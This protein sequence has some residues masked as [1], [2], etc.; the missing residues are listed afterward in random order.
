MRKLLLFITALAVIFA[1][2]VLVAC[3]GNNA[4]TDRN[5]FP[6][7]EEAAIPY[8]SDFTCNYYSAGGGDGGLIY[9]SDRSLQY[10]SEEEILIKIGFTLST[11][12]F[13]VGKTSLTIKPILSEGFFGSLIRANT[14]S[15]DDSDLTAVY[16]ADD[17]T[18]KT[19]TIEIKT[20]FNYYNGTIKIGYRYDSDE[21]KTTGSY[22][23]LCERTLKFTYDE[24]T[25]GYIA[26]N[27]AKDGKNWLTVPSSIEMPSEF[28]GKPI[29]G[30]AENMFSGCSS[31]KNLTLPNELVTIGSGAFRGCSSM[32]T[33]SIPDSVTHIG[34][35]AFDMCDSLEFYGGSQGCYYL[36]NETNEILAL[37]KLNK[38]KNTTKSITIHD[39]T[40]II[41]DGLFKDYDKLTEIR[42]G[43]GVT[44]IC[45]ELFSGCVY[46]TY[47]TIGSGVTSIGS[48][49]FY[50]CIRMTDVNIPDGVTAI[51]DY[52]FFDCSSVKNLTLPS[53][54]TTIGANAFYRC[55]HGLTNV[56]L[57][58]GLTT[59]ESETFYACTDLENITIP[60]GVTSIGFG[61]FGECLWLTSVMIPDSVTSIGK[62]AFNGCRSLT[63]ITIPDTVTSIGSGAFNGCRSLTSVTLPNGIKRIE[64]YTFI[65]CRSLTSVTLPN[66]IKKIERSAFY[67]S[68]LTSLILPDGLTDID[69]YAFQGC[70]GLT[71]LTVPN[72]VTSI[73]GVAFLD[74]DSLA[75]IRFGGTTE[76]WIE[77]TGTAPADG[78]TTV[79]CKNGEL[80]FDC[81]VTIK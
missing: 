66:G 51:G 20:K 63:N 33:I 28:N 34:S 25:D 73:S 19:C 55:N 75:E 77:L 38:T 57:P 1:A 8:V 22:N 56:T 15:F 45:D 24:E 31:L 40:K 36:G 29:T 72:T 21:F 49:A 3:G 23:L 5:D 18:A 37:V 61:A 11:D 76:E 30:I 7:E 46:L 27:D 69:L 35:G 41:A 17:K 26:D 39:D 80:K 79:R 14:S 70:S 59:I 32:E 58:S 65:G 12:A 64:E 50:D 9:P 6:L 71:S 48:K 74:C 13:K 4:A 81:G 53:G 10:K 47:V 54:V 43:N 78:K 67:G 68:G 16:A 42:I 62:D 44:R 60:S 2:F 52:A